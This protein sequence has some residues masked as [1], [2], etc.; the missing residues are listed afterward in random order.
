MT[1]EMPIPHTPLY[2]GL[3]TFVANVLGSVA[4]SKPKDIDDRAGQLESKASE[5]RELVEECRDALQGVFG[6]GNWAGSA[7]DSGRT[8]IDGLLGELTQRAERAEEEARSLRLIA[9]LLD[10]AQRYYVQQATVAERIIGRLMVNP[11]SRP[12]AQLMA[13]MMGYQLVQMMSR[14]AEA[15][16]AVGDGKF[17]ALWNDADQVA[18]QS[19]AYTST[20]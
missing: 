3:A 15:L 12:L 8:L 5:L 16:S 13:V 14:F 18:G 10:A 7:A 11:F 2:L 17:R 4:D 1:L 6:L 19:F 9:Q 20:R